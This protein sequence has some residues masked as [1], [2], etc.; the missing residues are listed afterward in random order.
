MSSSTVFPRARAT[1]SGDWREVNA[2]MAARDLRHFCA[3]D[4]A[5]LEILEKAARKFSFSARSLDRVLRVSRTIA[6]LAEKEKVEAGHLMEAMQYRCLE[7][8]R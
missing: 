8:L 1:S 5:G 6:D 3:V 2:F 4:A 7:R